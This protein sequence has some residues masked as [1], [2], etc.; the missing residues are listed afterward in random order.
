MNNAIQVKRFKKK[1]CRAIRI[2]EK[3]RKYIDL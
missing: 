3:Y 2:N 1:R